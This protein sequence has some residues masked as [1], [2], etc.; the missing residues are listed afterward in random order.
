MLRSRKF[1]AAAFA[2]QKKGRSKMDL[3]PRNPQTV[4]PEQD[5]G[6]EEMIAGCN[7][8]F[9]PLT[10]IMFQIAADRTSAK[11]FPVQIQIVPAVRAHQQTQYAIGIQMEPPSEQ[12][13]FRLSPRNPAPDAGES[14]KRSRRI[15]FL[16]KGEMSCRFTVRRIRLMKF[17]SI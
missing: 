14:P 10:V 3:A 11:Q 17:C 6:A 1:L 16:S 9:I 5:L 7:V 13:I 12:R 8:L 4:A 2:Q 15:F